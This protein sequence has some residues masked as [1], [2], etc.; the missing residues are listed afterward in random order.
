MVHYFALAKL[1]CGTREASAYQLAAIGQIC[2]TLGT[3]E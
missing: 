1:T 3:V 2:M